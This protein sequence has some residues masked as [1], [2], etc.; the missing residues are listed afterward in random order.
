MSKTR[1]AKLKRELKL[2]MAGRNM[3]KTASGKRK[4]AAEFE[5]FVGTMNQPDRTDAKVDK[6]ATEGWKASEV[7][8]QGHGWK[9]DQRDDVGFGIPKTAAAHKKAVDAT[10][11]AFV[12]LGEDQPDSILERQAREFYAMPHKAILSTFRRVRKL[13]AND[14]TGQED[15]PEYREVE[16]DEDVKGELQEVTDA[17][18]TDDEDEVDSLAQ[19]K[20]QAKSAKK[21]TSKEVV[22]S[23]LREL[24]AAGEEDE[25]E[26]E[27]TMFAEEDE[28]EDED[29]DDDEVLMDAHTLDDTTDSDITGESEG[30]EDDVLALLYDSKPESSK[31]AKSKGR[32]R[33][34]SVKKLGRV[35]SGDSGGVTDEISALRGLWGKTPRVDWKAVDQGIID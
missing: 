8:D 34:A 24:L 22:D 11:L 33:T 7:P 30:D 5:E 17:G 19:A 14:D 4:L 35:T 27:D 13:I 25:D 18:P 1:Q 23:E 9:S 3:P 12:V 2:F 26:D 20:K 29:E 6:Y 28:D 16:D 31:T 15:N 21:R 10:R 32:K